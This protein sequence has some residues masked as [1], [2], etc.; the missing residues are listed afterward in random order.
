MGNVNMGTWSEWSSWTPFAETKHE[1]GQFYPRDGNPR[2]PIYD[3]RTR[4]L[5][6]QDADQLESIIEAQQIRPPLADE[7]HLPRDSYY[8][9]TQNERGGNSQFLTQPSREFDRRRFTDF[10]AVRRG[11]NHQR[12][13]QAIY[14]WNNKYIKKRGIILEEPEDGSE[15]RLVFPPNYEKKKKKEKSE[16]RRRKKVGERARQNEI[17]GDIHLW[18]QDYFAGSEQIPT[19]YDEENE[20]EASFCCMRGLIREAEQKSR[21]KSVEHNPCRNGRHVHVIFVVK[22]EEDILE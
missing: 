7:Q 17:A 11:P 4:F 10:L 18:Y 15:V 20:H 13:K 8:R 5:I 3:Y 2:F 6:F 1:L 9:F 12:S 22:F 16:K 21:Q 19:D 14:K